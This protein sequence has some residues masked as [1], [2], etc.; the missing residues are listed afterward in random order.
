M[1]VGGILS[2]QGMSFDR[3]VSGARAEEVLADRQR[4]V[5][6]FASSSSRI[7]GHWHEDAE[8]LGRA[9]GTAGL[10]LAYG[11]CD[12]GLMGAAARSARGA[13]CPVL[14]VIP[15]SLADL[16]ESDEACDELVVVPDLAARKQVLVQR[17]GSFVCLP[18]GIGT[19]DEIFEVLALRQVGETTAPLVLINRDGFYDPLLALIDH[20]RDLGFV[21]G[22]IQTG[23]SDPGLL[24]A[25]DGAKAVDLLSRVLGR[26]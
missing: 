24:V 4:V 1:E 15:Q 10:A 23:D 21:R 9:L 13:G 6:V 25:K 20:A 5:S 22:L 3:V 26:G 16:G 8:L 2:W 14:G 19:F 12:L 7:S 18:G 17:S 11:G